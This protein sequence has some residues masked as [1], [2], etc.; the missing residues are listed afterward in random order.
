M[1][2]LPISNYL[3]KYLKKQKSSFNI[4]KSVIKRN[5]SE[6]LISFHKKDNKTYLEK[7]RKLFEYYAQL[8]ESVY[9]TK[10]CI[11]KFMKLCN[12]MNIIDKNLNKKD[13]EFI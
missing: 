4:N 3:E 9:T 12:D 8:G 1:F 13:L 5:Q 2:N 10:I 7:M 6:A 11:K